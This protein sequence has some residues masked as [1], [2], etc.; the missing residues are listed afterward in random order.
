MKARRALAKENASMVPRR[1][2]MS[3]AISLVRSRQRA[4]PPERPLDPR[5]PRHAA[6]LL[7]QRLNVVLSAIG[8]A[9]LFAAP[10]Q[11]AIGAIAAV[12]VV[13]GAAVALHAWRREKGLRDAHA[14]PPPAPARD[15]LSL[16]DVAGAYVFFGCVAAGLADP[17]AIARLF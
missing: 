11:V 17:D 12:L 16:W 8:A 6:P 13:A 4:A 15:D 9:L 10:R 1:S 5:D 7:F 3:I 2:A 14:A